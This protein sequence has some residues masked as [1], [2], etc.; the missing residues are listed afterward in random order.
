MAEGEAPSQASR[1]KKKGRRFSAPCYSHSYGY[2]IATF[3][4]DAL[5]SVSTLSWTPNILDF[6]QVLK[7][8]P[9][10]Q[11]TKMRRPR[12]GRGDAPWQKRFTFRSKVRQEV[13]VPQ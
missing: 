13:A 10:V 7:H 4:S 9:R 6:R 11:P 8:S 3:R 5:T 2:P 12:I 1:T